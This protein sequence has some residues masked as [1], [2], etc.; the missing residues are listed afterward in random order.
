MGPDAPTLTFLPVLPSLATWGLPGS[1]SSRGSTGIWVGECWQRRSS[2][3]LGV[4]SSEF[5][6]QLW[7]GALYASHFFSGLGCSRL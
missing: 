3:E 2:T 1:S 6:P 5:L 4:K 7:Y